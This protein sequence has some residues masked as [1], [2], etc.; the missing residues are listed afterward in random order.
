MELIGSRLLIPRHIAILSQHALRLLPPLRPRSSWLPKGRQQES[1]SGWDQRRKCEEME[2]AINPSVNLDKS[3]GPVSNLNWSLCY[4]ADGEKVATGSWGREEEEYRARPTTGVYI[5]LPPPHTRAPPTST[6]LC[7]TS[8]SAL[9]LPPP[10]Q[11]LLLCIDWSST[12]SPCLVYLHLLL[13]PSHSRRLH[14]AHSL[15]H[16]PSR[17][18]HRGKRSP[19]ASNSQIRPRPSLSV[20]SIRSHVLLLLLLCSCDGHES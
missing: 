9:L 10:I 19:V 16:R 2:S 12:L 7:S 5:S 6:F 17:T 4:E 14:V 1:M 18:R 8:S 15:S 20:P 11:L 13:S 3:T